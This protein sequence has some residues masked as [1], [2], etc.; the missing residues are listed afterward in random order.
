MP[1]RSRGIWPG[2]WSH[3]QH[4]IAEVSWKPVGHVRE[5]M[6]R[7]IRDDP[8]RTPE[9]RYLKPPFFMKRIVN[10]A[11]NGAWRWYRPGHAR[12]PETC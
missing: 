7:D 11:L 4:S 6:N 5:A 3:G 2:L 10:P 9:R 12:W 8:G 1:S